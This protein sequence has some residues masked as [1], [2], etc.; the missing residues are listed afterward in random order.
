MMIYAD[1]KL[2]AGNIKVAGSFMTRLIGLL[3]KKTLAPGEGLLLTPCRQIHTWFM[4]FEIDVVFLDNNGQIMAS[5]AGMKPGLASPRVKNCCR[6]LEM[7]AGSI[8]KHNLHIGT[9][10]ETR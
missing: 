5:I 8:A 1:N 3:G 4:S 7:A 2:I 9:V 10:L 6:V